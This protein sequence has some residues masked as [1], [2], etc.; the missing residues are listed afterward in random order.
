MTQDFLFMDMNYCKPSSWAGLTLIIGLGLILAGCGDGRPPPGEMAPGQEPYLRWCAQCHGNQGEGKPPAFPPLAGSE[1][2]E[3]PDEAMAL[4]VLYG[5]R[6]EIEV[7]GRSY[8]GYMPP[9]QHLRDG[10]IAELIGYMLDAWGGRESRLS[11][12]DIARLRGAF[13]GRRPPLDG[14]DGVEAALSE[15]GVAR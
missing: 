14:L 8:N 12:Q 4:I 10:D 5:L 1:W 13:Q 11:E 9:M 3:L 2:L 6:G 7:A 15:V